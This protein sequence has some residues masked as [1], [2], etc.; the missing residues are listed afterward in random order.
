MQTSHDA[1]RLDLLQVPVPSAI[2][3]D[4]YV[5][6]ASRHVNASH[7]LKM[8]RRKPLE[9]HLL[10]KSPTNQAEIGQAAA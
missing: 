5:N 3:C 9:A 6:I 10:D 1:S 8:L 4:K 2:K 7:S